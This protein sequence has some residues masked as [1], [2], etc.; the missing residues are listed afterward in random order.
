MYVLVHFYFSRLLLSSR[1]LFARGLVIHKICLNSNIAREYINFSLSNL[2]FT[3]VDFDVNMRLLAYDPIKLYFPLFA[4][5]LPLIF[6]IS[7]KFRSEIGWIL[8]VIVED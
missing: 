3:L 5:M 4:Y 6:L 7:I 2:S 1:I 8:G